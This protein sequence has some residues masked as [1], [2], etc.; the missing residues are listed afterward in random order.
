MTKLKQCPFCGS[1]VEYCIDLGR[2]GICCMECNVRIRGFYNCTRPE[3]A[4]AWNTRVE[5]QQAQA[6]IDRL[7]TLLIQAH[8]HECIICG[9]VADTFCGVPV[10]E[11]IELVY[12]NGG[13]PVHDARYNPEYPTLVCILCGQTRDT[14]QCP[15]EE[16]P[17]D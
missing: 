3:I 4:E 17:N 1:E 2:H 6:E 7:K 12:R 11:A 16:Q 9:E 5:L 14:P 8:K 15:N 13:S 10:E